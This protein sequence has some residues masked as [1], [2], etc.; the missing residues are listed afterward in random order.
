LRLEVELVPGWAPGRSMKPPQ[1]A[2]MTLAPFEAAGGVPE[3]KK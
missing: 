1:P 3:T 2:V